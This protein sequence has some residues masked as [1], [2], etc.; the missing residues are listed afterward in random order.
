MSQ[1]M[2]RP[3]TRSEAAVGAETW[4]A[5][6]QDALT[7]RD[8]DGAAAMFAPTS[9]WRDLVA[10]T[11]NITTVEGPDGVAEMLRARLD[12]TDPTGFHAVE[13]PTETDGVTD[14][15]L[16]FE[17]AVGRGSGHLRLQNGKAFTLLTTLD[18]L[19]GFEEPMSARRPR[20]V[21]H[22]VHPNR[23]NFPERR[24]EE[25]ESFGRTTQPYVLVVGG[26]QGGIAL[27]AR[28]RSIGVPA[29]IVERNERP[30]DSWRKRYKHLALHDPVWY[31]HLPYLPF[32]K[33][34]PVFSPKDKIADWLEMYTRVMEVN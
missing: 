18:E 19:K 30:G 13:E 17:T 9:F 16:E 6:F 28:L 7:A 21:E 31:D 32:P 22:G 33:N 15:W 3:A 4:L 34:W 25:V 5:A 12:D 20:G 11:W 27:G 2:D 23:K 8:I 14:V 1:T 26:G 29:L 10:F 24:A